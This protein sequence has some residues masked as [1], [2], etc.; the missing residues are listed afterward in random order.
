[1]RYQKSWGHFDDQ[2]QE[3]ST[4]KMQGYN[5]SL[6]QRRVVFPQASMRR[7][8]NITRCSASYCQL[9]FTRK[10]IDA[11]PCAALI[12]ETHKFIS[13]QFIRD[14]LTTRRK[15]TAQG[16]AR[17]QSES[18]LARVAFVQVSKRRRRK[19]LLVSQCDQVYPVQRIGHLP[20]SANM[21]ATLW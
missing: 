10:N 2:T 5:L 8:R 11:R 17:I 15:N 21:E 14:S 20:N 13:Y 7:R 4:W 3:C 9:A 19:Q 12:R 18:I 6:S 16:N 1:M